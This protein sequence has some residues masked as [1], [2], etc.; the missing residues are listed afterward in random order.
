M[1]NTEVEEEKEEQLQLKSLLIGICCGVGLCIAIVVA[2][3]FRILTGSTYT[4]YKKIKN[5]VDKE[6]EIQSYISESYIFDQDTKAA[7][8]AVCVALV[9]ALGDEYSQYFP[10]QEYTTISG[11]FENDSSVQEKLLEGNIGYIAINGFVESSPAEFKSGLDS[12]LGS[13]IKGLIVDVRDNPGGLVNQMAECLDYLVD[14]GKMFSVTYASGQSEELKAT[15]GG[16]SI[17]CIVLINN[18]TISAAE[19]FAGVLQKDIGA[20]LIG[21]NTFGKGVM[22]RYY[23]FE[24]SSALRIT[25]ATY[26]FADGTKMSST[27]L[28]PEIV[29]LDDECLDSA[30]G[31]MN[32][33]I[34]K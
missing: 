12:L 17:P 28:E 5:I 24:D 19:L 21:Q 4:S 9:D 26:E 13:G 22:Q 33:L 18:K 34:R 27:G 15:E 31:Y 29:V 7:E 14:E 1:F 8:D 3:V 25:F 16:I 30:V 11:Y 6:I 32:E 10:A 20:V 23:E 2:V